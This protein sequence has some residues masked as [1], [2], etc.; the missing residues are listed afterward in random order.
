RGTLR[1]M[2]ARSWSEGISKAQ[3]SRV[4]GHKRALGPER[5]YVRQV[6]PRAVFAGIRGWLRGEDPAGLGRA[7]VIIAVLAATATGYVRG[8]RLPAAPV[9]LKP[10]PVSAEDAWR[11]VQ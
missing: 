5:R 4:V 10:A 3:V 7:A 8:R 6:L 1:Y 9:P 2:L 11:E